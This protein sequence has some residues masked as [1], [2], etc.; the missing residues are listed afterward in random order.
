MFQY[1]VKN[2]TNKRFLQIKKMETELETL[3]EQFALYSKKS[4]LFQLLST[5]AALKC[6]AHIKMR[7]H[8]NKQYKVR[9]PAFCNKYFGQK[10]DTVNTRILT[11]LVKIDVYLAK[12]NR[13]GEL[14]D[15]EGTP[16]FAKLTADIDFC[17][18][19]NYIPFPSFGS[20]VTNAR[21][22]IAN[23]MA[24]ILIEKEEAEQKKAEQEAEVFVAVQQ[25]PP[26]QSPSQHAAA[27][28]SS[29]EIS[30][31]SP[32]GNG[33]EASPSIASDFSEELETLQDL[34]NEIFDADV[35][36]D[37]ENII[38]LLDAVIYEAERLKNFADEYNS[39]AGF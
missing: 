5:T 34:V 3:V 6:R 33:E 11:R 31:G 15:N 16:E 30:L 9:W 10:S 28:E 24:R 23:E 21:L 18:R 4:I 14:I 13:L 17:C 38:L 25:P 32:A 22:I 2:Q 1:C 36:D 35:D 26:P 37:N 19:A 7:K 20:I 39:C 29:E 27:N 12:Q 8:Q